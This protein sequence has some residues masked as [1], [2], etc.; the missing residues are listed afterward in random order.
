M[1]RE[2]EGRRGEG[3]GGKGGEESGGKGEKEREERRRRKSE[4]VRGE[5]E[6]EGTEDV[7]CLQQVYDHIWWLPSLQQVAILQPCSH[8]LT[9]VQYQ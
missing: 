5:M 3:R 9:F 7:I 1:E 2:G 8:F 4:G 6:R